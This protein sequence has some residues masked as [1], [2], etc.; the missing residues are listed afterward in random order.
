MY[1]E[2][3]FSSQGYIW[4]ITDMNRR[5]DQIQAGRSWVRTN[6]AATKMGLALHPIS[7]ALQEYPEMAEI[8]QLIHQ[9]LAPNGGTVQMLGRLGYASTIPPS[10]RWSINHKIISA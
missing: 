6:L 8:Y 2:I 3:L 10:P 4:L 1:R 7:Q 5:E 9:R